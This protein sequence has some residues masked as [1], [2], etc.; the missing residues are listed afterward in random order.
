[1]HT[2]PDTLTMSREAVTGRQSFSPPD[3]GRSTPI[4]RTTRKT[5]E[6]GMWVALAA[7]HSLGLHSNILQTCTRPTR[8]SADMLQTLNEH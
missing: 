6:G 1:M 7:E 5:V 2:N 8:V 4:P 3:S